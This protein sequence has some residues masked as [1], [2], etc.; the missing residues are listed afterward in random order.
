MVKERSNDRAKSEIAEKGVRSPLGR[1]LP[2]EAGDTFPSVV[3]REVTVAEAPA[4][5]RASASRN[6]SGARV[7]GF[8]APM[9]AAG[10]Y[11]D[12]GVKGRTSGSSVAGSSS[13]SYSVRAHAA[14]RTTLPE[15]ESAS[16]EIIKT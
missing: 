5:R 3:R 1:D 15:G 11:Q 6:R 13:V 4:V 16:A 7:D 12:A 8:P 2:N 9:I 14:S 10:R